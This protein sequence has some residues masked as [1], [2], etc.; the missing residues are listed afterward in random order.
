MRLGG[1]GPVDT[2]EGNGA[3]ARGRPYLQIARERHVLRLAQKHDKGTNAIPC[4]AAVSFQRSPQVT[5]CE[6]RVRFL[7]LLGL[8]KGRRQFRLKAPPGAR[9]PGAAP[10]QTVGRSSTTCAIPERVSTVRTFVAEVISS[11]VSFMQQQPAIG[12]GFKLIHPTPILETLPSRHAF[13]SLP[14]TSQIVR[15]DAGKSG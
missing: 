15:R 11:I 7:Q 6:P 2:R 9:I 3:G 8:T 1:R 10:S 14:L 4:T 5:T 12:P 13:L